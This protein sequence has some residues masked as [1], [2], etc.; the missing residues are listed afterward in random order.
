MIYN[1]PSPMIFSQVIPDHKEVKD[2]LMP[3]IA[4]DIEANGEIYA[5]RASWFCD[6]TSSYF[7]NGHL[8]FITK[9]VVESIVWNP[10]RQF[11][12]E[13]PEYQQVDT[14]NPIITDL[15]YNSYTSGQYQEP[16]THTGHRSSMVFSGIYL[17]DLHEEN[18][19]RF[20]SPAP[21]WCREQEIHKLTRECEEG[22]VLIFP[23]S[24]MHYVVPS[25][26][27]KTTISFNIGEQP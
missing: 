8:D 17:L 26:A 1:F 22:T 23:S 3:K 10:L 18:T 5:A 16:H 14:I 25:K 7:R 12:R 6:I 4:D 21:S 9:E 15:W 13:V 20:I 27:Q 24:L 2:Y 19:T 11:Y